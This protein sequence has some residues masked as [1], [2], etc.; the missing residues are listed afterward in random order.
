MKIVQIENGFVHWDA[1]SEIPSI[2]WATE[3]YANNI[4][5][6]EAPDYVREGWAFYEEL[7]GDAR[8]IR[9]EAPDGWYYDDNTG[10]FRPINEEKYE[11]MFVK[12]LRTAIN[13]I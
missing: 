7:E 13:N 6:V 11:S 4:F 12:E 5:F 1:S 2:E 10:T 9:P 3:H 8:F